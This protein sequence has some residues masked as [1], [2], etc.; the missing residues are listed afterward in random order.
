M[1]TYLTSLLLL[2]A[3]IAILSS[4]CAQEAP[5]QQETSVAELIAERPIDS[6]Q[7]LAFSS[8]IRSIFEDSRGHFWFG[9][10]Q[11]GVCRFDGEKLTYFTVEDGLSNNQVRSIFEDSNGVVWFECG[12]GLSKYANG[13]ITTPPINNYLVK[14]NWQTNGQDLWFKGNEVHGYNASEGQPGVY[15]YDGHRLTY[16]AFPV[17]V[18]AEDGAYYSVSTPFARGQNNR[19]WFGTYGAV[20]GYTP[21]TVPL[22]PAGFTIINNERLGLTEESGYLHV[23]SILEDSR[24]RLWIGNNGIGVWHYDGDSSI[25]FSAQQGLISEDSGRSGGFHSPSGSLEHVFAIGED[26]EGNI[27]FGDRDT[28][29]W[30]YDG[31]SMT[32]YTEANGLTTTHIWQFYETSSGEWWCALGDGSVCRFTGNGLERVF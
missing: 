18:G 29:A 31:E 16:H 4:S 12:I 19:L 14:E 8:G 24:G 9:S 25:H 23:R 7:F 2:T 27:W 30:R 32:N 5:E 10:H 15:R 6:T 17:T 28:G 13:K 21:S 26:G 22:G 20:I 1:N 11:E 3:S